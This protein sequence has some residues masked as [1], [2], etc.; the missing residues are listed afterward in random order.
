M[1]RIHNHQGEAS[2]HFCFRI[3]GAQNLVDVDVS[4]PPLLC[5]DTLYTPASS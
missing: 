2:P 1:Q 4:L 5:R 3:V